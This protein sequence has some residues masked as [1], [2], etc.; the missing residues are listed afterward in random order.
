M[1]TVENTE[2]AMGVA[3]IFSKIPR[4]SRLF[5]Q[6]LK[7]YTVLGFIAFL[8]TSL[9]KFAW[10]SCFNPPS[11]PTVGKKEKFCAVTKK[12]YFLPF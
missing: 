3:Q 2:R 5:G 11:P 10:R 8:L 4:G 7:G 1:Y 9:K 6:K 12:I